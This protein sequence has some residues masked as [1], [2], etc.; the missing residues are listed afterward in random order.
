MQT[1]P[2]HPTDPGSCVIPTQNPSGWGESSDPPPPGAN[3]CHGDRLPPIRP[4]AEGSPSILGGTH[5]WDRPQH[6]ASLPWER[7]PAAS[8]HRG[9]LSMLQAMGASLSPSGSPGGFGGPLRSPGGS[10][11]PQ[12]EETLHRDAL[13]WHRRVP[14]RWGGAMQGGGGR[15]EP[16]QRFDAVNCTPIPDKL[17]QEAFPAPSL[18]AAPLTGWDGT[19]RTAPTRRNLLPG[20]RGGCKG[21]KDRRSSK[22]P[23]SKV[24]FPPSA[25]LRGS[26]ASPAPLG[27]T[28][29]TL[30]STAPLHFTLFKCSHHSVAQ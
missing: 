15:L 29:R 2:G 1:P 9:G 25:V 17:H 5:Q 11:G 20:R 8:Q 14:W 27:R 21:C 4:G 16:L 12:K 6:G 26:S 13:P 7:D 22:K 3:G 24:Q 10:G 30:P 18:P 23:P 19:T 28:S